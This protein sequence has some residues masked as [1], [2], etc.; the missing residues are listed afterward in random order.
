MINNFFKE[1]SW[2]LVGRSPLLH[3]Q[4][5]CFDLPI[6]HLHVTICQH[7]IVHVDH[8]QIGIEMRTQKEVASSSFRI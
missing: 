3:P 7:A 6:L 5:V 8:G 1:V 4:W 2:D